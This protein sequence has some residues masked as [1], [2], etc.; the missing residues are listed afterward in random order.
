MGRIDSGWISG[1]MKP[2][3]GWDQDPAFKLDLDPSPW[4]LGLLP[5]CLD[6][7]HFFRLCRSEQLLL[8]SCCFTQGKGN[9]FS[10]RV[11]L[12]PVPTLLWMQCRPA[13]LP[14]PWQVRI[15][16]SIS[17]GQFPHEWDVFLNSHVYDCVVRLASHID[18]QASLIS[19]SS[20]QSPCKVMNIQCRVSHLLFPA[21]SALQLL[22]LDLSVLPK[23]KLLPFFQQIPSTIFCCCFKT[24]HRFFIIC[25]YSSKSY[26]LTFPICTCLF[27]RDW[28]GSHLFSSLFSVLLDCCLL[29][30]LYT[31]HSFLFLSCC[32]L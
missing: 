9:Y 3:S 11:A 32:V 22:L 27:H 16:L 17:C 18:A 15:G 30:Q 6:L 2:G 4:Q 10:F 20:P 26:F 1:R 7:Q 25:L 12:Q 31:P 14:P 5:V 21:Y 29:F 24:T 23:A 13:G 28:G 19:T 8:S